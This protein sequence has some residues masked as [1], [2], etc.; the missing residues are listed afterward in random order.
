MGVSD[1]MNTL[2]KICLVLTIL[3][4]L[5][6]GLIALLD[7]NLVTAIFGNDTMVSNAIYLL[8]GLAGLI[9]IGLL[10]TPFD[11]ETRK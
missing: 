11:K 9:N 7:L 1:H 2:Q 5:N 6:W 10:F 3:G 8:I 4:A